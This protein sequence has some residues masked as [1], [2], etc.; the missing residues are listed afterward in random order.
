MNEHIRACEG[1]NLPVKLDAAELFSLEL[2]GPH[3]VYTPASRIMLLI[4]LTRNEP[5]PA[6]ALYKRADWVQNAHQQQL[7]EP[8]KHC[9]NRA[10]SWQKSSWNLLSAS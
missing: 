9:E 1:V 7:A 8:W 2:L 10:V 3:C 6:Q 4:D 5:E